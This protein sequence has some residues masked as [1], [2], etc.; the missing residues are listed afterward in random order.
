[1]LLKDVASLSDRWVDQPNR[2]YFN[3]KPAVVFTINNTIEEDLIAITDYVKQ[4][5]ER[6]KIEHPELET[7]IVQD[8]SVVVEQRT[9]LL[10]NNGVIGA[11]LVLVLLALFLNIRLAFWVALGIPVSFMGLFIVGAFMGMSINVISLFGMI[12]VVGILVDDGVVISEN[13]YQHYEKGEKPLQAAVNG[14]LE[15]MPAIISAIITTCLSFSV[16]FFLDGRVGDIISDIAFVV[17]ATLLFSLVEGLLILPAHVAHSK[18]LKQG[19]KKAGFEKWTN[20]FF[21]Y[22]RDRLYAPVLR[23]CLEN[24]LFAMAIPIALLMITFGMMNGGFIKTTF[25]PFVERDNINVSLLLNQPRYCPNVT[26]CR[27]SVG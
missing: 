23:F 19:S 7:N 2:S 8:Q 14:V 4:Y 17:V 5:L 24:K 18:A 3:G 6:F 21:F 11:I 13:I 15:V 27:R 10:I 20:G 22:I 1:V 26:R 16:F 9:G 12:V 25:F